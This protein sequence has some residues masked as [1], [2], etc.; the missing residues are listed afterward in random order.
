MKNPQNLLPDLLQIAQKELPLLQHDVKNASTLYTLQAAVD[1][2]A[3]IVQYIL[4]HAINEGYVALTAQQALPQQVVAP[5]PVQRMPVAAPAP[6]GFPGSLPPIGGAA[7][8]EP[9]NNQSSRVVEVS[10]TPSGTRVQAPG[11]PQ[12]VLPPGA[13]VDAAA[14][15]EPQAPPPGVIVPPGGGA[16]SEEVA[17]AIAA[18]SGG[19][20]NVTHDPAGG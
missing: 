4:H 18:A 17:A 12:M 8:P 9:Q 5:A 20:R 19:A 6:V 11:A 13:Y 16:M 1:R 2:L 14:L 3:V 15:V 7:A 10:I